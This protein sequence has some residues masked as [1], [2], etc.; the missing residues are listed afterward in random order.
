MDMSEKISTQIIQ[1][2]KALGAASAGIASVEAL[3]VA[4]TYRLLERADMSTLG[5]GSDP[6]GS[7]NQKVK[8]LEKA[9]S[10]L[11]IAVSHPKTQPELDWFDGRQG[12][13]GN[14]ILI[15]I[16]KLLS[17]WIEKN[18]GIKTHRLPYY[19]QSGGVFLKDAAV[20]AGLGCIG[21]GNLLVTPGLGPRV[22]LRAMFLEKILPPTGPIAFD[23]CVDCK[24]YCRRSC[25]EHA[26]DRTVHHSEKMGIADLPGRDGYYSKPTCSSGLDK[27]IAESEVEVESLSGSALGSS[28]YFEDGSQLK[29]CIKYCRRCE[30]A[31]P[32][33]ASGKNE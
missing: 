17:D 3:K 4:P 32:V 28:L 16:N 10:V 11:V 15:Q 22:R 24:E 21:K 30:F 31:C 6:M 19:L 8:W 2:A 25:P 9:A 27:N 14:R 26:F 29:G 13:P 20:L 1:K 33:G 23:P 7:D 12:T 5:V 18:F